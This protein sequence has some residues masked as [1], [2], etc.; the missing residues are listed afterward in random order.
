MSLVKTDVAL[1]YCNN[2]VDVQAVAFILP[3]G[4]VGV[5]SHHTVLIVTVACPV[6]RQ[7]YVIILI[8]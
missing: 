5:T 8:L 4:N 7:Y 2:V 3:D 1:K 6:Y